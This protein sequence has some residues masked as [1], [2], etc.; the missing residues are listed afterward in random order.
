MTTGATITENNETFTRG[1]YNGISI[2]IRDKDGYVN[3]GR[4]CRDAGKDLSDYTKHDKFQKI[5]KY[6]IENEAPEVKGQMS[7]NS[8][9]Y[10]YKLSRKYMSCQGTYIHKDLIHFIAE[11]ISEEYAFKVK[12]IM[13]AVNENNFEK[14]NREIAEL[15]QENKQLQ[16][17]NAQLQE[18]S[19]IQD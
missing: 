17:K 13:D 10:K 4:L 11:W 5:L 8:E 6:W 19:D 1:V 14:L 2:L 9:T 16:E 3:A 18:K 15:Q 7:V 12:H